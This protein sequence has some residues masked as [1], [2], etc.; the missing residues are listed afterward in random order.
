MIIK[1]TKGLKIFNFLIKEYHINEQ[2]KRLKREKVKRIFVK[3]ETIAK[4]LFLCMFTRERSFNQ[5]IEKIHKR[6]KYK[7]MFKKNE[8]VPK[9][10]VF[11]DEVKELNLEELKQINKKIIIKTKENKIYRKGT[12]DNLVVVGIDGVETFESCKK[13]WKN[14]YKKKRKTEEYKN[15]IKQ[16]IEKE[17]HKP[18]NIFAKIVGMRPGLILG[19][20]KVTSEGL[21]GKQEYEPNVAIKLIKKLKK[22]YGRGIDVIVGDAIYLEEKFLKEVREEGYQAVI[23]LKDNRKSYLNEAEGLFRLQKAK[24]LKIKDRTIESWS[25]IIDYKEMKVKVAKFKEKY[26]KGKEIKED[27]IYVVS[28][29]LTM[30]EE[31]MNKIIHERWDIENEGFNELKNNWNMKHCYMADDK[32]ID[33]ILQMIIMSYNLWELYIYGHLHN[34]ENK[35]MTKMG[36]IES[37]VEEISKAK[38]TEIEFSSA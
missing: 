3:G 30:R 24:K 20:E 27:T 2:M 7:N 11:R 15:G 9:M 13:D 35:N 10:H 25:E 21:E 6:K 12:I 34:F 23:R 38:Y 26:K 5:L 31:T 14:S 33:I 18:I 8:H 37:I 1:K 22:V 36:Y 16:E 17:Y 19:Y 28:T 29:D 32:A 4:M